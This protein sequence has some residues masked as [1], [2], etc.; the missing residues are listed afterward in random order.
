MTPMTAPAY[1][2]NGRAVARET[3]YAIACDPRRSVAVEACAG[4]GKTWMLVSRILRAL[5]A[6]SA[7]HEILAITFTKKAAAEMRQRLQEWLAEFAH[8]TPEQLDQEL[9]ARGLQP[10]PVLREALQN[11]YQSV[12]AVGHPVQIRTFHGWFAALLRTAPMSVLQE[13][14]LPT[15]YELLENDSQAI[16]LVWRRFNRAVLADAVAQQDYRAAVAQHGRHQTSRRWR[17]R[18]PSALNLRWPTRM[19]WSM[20]RCGPS[21][22]SFPTLPTWMIPTSCWRTARRARPLRWLPWRW[23]ARRSPVSAPRAASWSR[24]CTRATSMPCWLP[25]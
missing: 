25:C 18:C 24:R 23:D 7:P 14:G 8:A 19:A 22:I 20:P 2:H 3:F 13:L 12:L 9:S 15:Q 5:L 4:S 1:E 17:L 10:T 16:A 21:A 6:G 11:L